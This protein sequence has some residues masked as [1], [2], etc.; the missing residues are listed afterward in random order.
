[1]GLPL[2]LVFMGQIIILKPLKDSQGLRLVTGA[3]EFAIVD[4][5]AQKK[6]LDFA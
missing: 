5:A 4:R 1:M 6:H 2:V 3:A